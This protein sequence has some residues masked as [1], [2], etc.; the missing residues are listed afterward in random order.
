MKHLSILAI[1]AVISIWYLTGC[2]EKE[3]DA[4]F[5][6]TVLEIHEKSILVEPFEG[7]EELKSSDRILASSITNSNHKVPEMKEGTTVRIVYDGII[8]ETYPAQINEVY[9]IYLVNSEGEIIEDAEESPNVVVTAVTDEKTEA[10]TIN[11]EQPVQNKNTPP[12][13]ISYDS[14]DRVN[15]IPSGKGRES[16]QWLTEKERLRYIPLGNR[17]NLDFPDDGTPV[18]VTLSDIILDESGK[19][20][21]SED[22]INVRSLTAEEGRYSIYV[23]VNLNAMYSNNPEA[24]QPAG[25]IRGFLLDCLFEDGK[26]EEYAAA[27][28]T[29]A[30]FGLSEESSSA[31]LM[32]ICGT[33]IDIFAQSQLQ[34]GSSGLELIFTVNNESTKEFYY[35]EQPLL[36]RFEG[37]DLKEI[38]L[39]EGVGWND[40][41]YILAPGKS[42]EQKINLEQIYGTLQ[43][44][45]YRFSKEFT[46]SQNGESQVV[47]DDFVIN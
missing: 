32:Y 30:A 29:D 28:K 17:L 31:F 22:K 26:T 39:L 33:G 47:S 11:Q 36:E 21:Y 14:N 19:P 15:D 25:I 1:L 43:P 2:S 12:L 16:F 8:A 34:K 13:S 18:S 41:A 10:D 38:P 23:D 40:L 9:A 4:Y 6:A 44:G 35:G 37:P 27:F 24:Y 45:Y 46:D 7:S 3:T 5:N 42:A 20:K